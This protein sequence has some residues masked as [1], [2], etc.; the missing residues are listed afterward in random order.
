[1]K[2]NSTKRK[3]W[4]AIALGVLFNTSISY[5]IS[6][7]QYTAPASFKVF[8]GYQYVFVLGN[9]AMHGLILCGNVI[10]NA[11]IC[12]E[13]CLLTEKDKREYNAYVSSY[14]VYAFIGFII[15]SLDSYFVLVYGFVGVTCAYI[16]S[17]SAKLKVTRRLHHD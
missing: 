17:Y 1:M 9:I 4:I 6:E 15:C 11:Y 2:L 10:L 5:I 3:I 12:D 14:A 7:F 8:A 13:L 16:I